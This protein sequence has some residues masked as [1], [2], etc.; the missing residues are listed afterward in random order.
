MNFENPLFIFIRVFEIF[1]V[2]FKFRNQLHH[3]QYHLNSPK[4]GSLEYTLPT[5]NPGKHTITLR[6]WDSY[7]NPTEKRVE[8][9]VVS[10]DRLLITELMNYPNPFKRETSFSY[11]LSLPSQVDI[12]IFTLAGRLIKTIKNASGKAGYNLQ[13]W[14]GLDGDGD[15]IANGVYIYK[16]VARSTGSSDK[17]LKADAFGKAVVMK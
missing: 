2:A 3:F 12:E 6:A 15:R 5:L 14:D 7:N 8:F 9:T 17:T 11:Q 13:P 4:G 16:V 1:I 10:S